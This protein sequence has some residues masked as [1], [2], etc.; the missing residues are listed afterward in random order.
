MVVI[1]SGVIAIMAVICAFTAVALKIYANTEI[2][3]GKTRP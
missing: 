3:R 1:T 2:G